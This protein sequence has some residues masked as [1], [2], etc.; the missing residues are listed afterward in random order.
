MQET[1]GLSCFNQTW[2]GGLIWNVLHEDVKVVLKHQDVS[3]F[4][5]P[6]TFWHFSHKLGQTEEP[7]LALLSSQ[8][9]LFWK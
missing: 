6:Q 8:S 3:M 9:C 1:I 5:V 2:N 4:T 7:G